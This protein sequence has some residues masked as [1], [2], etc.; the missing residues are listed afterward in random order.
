MH[1]YLRVQR[2]RKQAALGVIQR[3]T[4]FVAGGFNAKNYHWVK[5]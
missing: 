1:R 2:V 4:R 3:Q 5:E